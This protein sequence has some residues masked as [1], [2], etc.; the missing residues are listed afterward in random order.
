MSFK[1]FGCPAKITK[2][3]KYSCSPKMPSSHWLGVSIVQELEL[4]P[5]IYYLQ[6]GSPV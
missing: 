3:R 2:A 5:E 6:K 1:K 4:E